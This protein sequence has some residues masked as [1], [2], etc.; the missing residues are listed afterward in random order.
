[1]LL[2]PS[3]VNT[4]IEPLPQPVCTDK[5]A[6]FVS[7]TSK[8]TFMVQQILLVKNITLDAVMLQ[9]FTQHSIQIHI[10]MDFLGTEVA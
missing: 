6:R 3:G 1:M 8:L 10:E 4:I 5:I 9:R 2:L 7:V